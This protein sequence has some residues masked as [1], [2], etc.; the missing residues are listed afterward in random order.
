MKHVDNVLSRK[1]KVKIKEDPNMIV[2]IS[3]LWL[4]LIELYEI[5]F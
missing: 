5:M 4:Y 3:L 1:S 2:F